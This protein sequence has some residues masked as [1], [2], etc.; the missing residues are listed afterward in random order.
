MIKKILASKI[1]RYI[2]SIVLLYF[3]FQKVNI[4]SLLKDLVSVPWWSVPALLAYLSI[5]M[6]VGGWRWAILV[7]DKVTIYDVLLFTKTNYLGGFYGLF[8]PTPFAGD[9]IKWT[10]L[11]SKYSNISKTR[12][13]G[14]ILIDRIIGFTALCV[15]ALIALVVG[16]IYGYFL[17]YYLWWVFG[18]INFGLIIFYLLTF[19]IDFQKIISHFKKLDKLGE[20]VGLLHNANK[21]DLIFVFVLCLI[22]EPIWM[23]TTWFISLIFGLNIRLLDALIFLPIIALILVLPIS[24]AG[25]GARETL[26][27]YF[28]SQLGLPVDKILAVSTFNGIL[29][30]FSSL[31]G[32]VLTF[33]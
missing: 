25:F 9:L 8:F 20:I 22:S 31:I 17:P 15:V 11:L 4:L 26:F 6:F 19:T 3:A 13:V 2:F 33:F 16:K 7:L 5:T 24:V 14:T 21:K 30:I 12:F 32:G 23:A 28:F 10:T 18:L 1:T 29:G 27:V